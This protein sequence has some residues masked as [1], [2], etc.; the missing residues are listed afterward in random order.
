MSP[1]AREKSDV[2]PW[3][4]REWRA[5]QASSAVVAEMTIRRSLVSKNRSVISFD[6]PSTPD[7]P[8]IGMSIW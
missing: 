8:T 6:Q 5:R 3:R 4:L 2:S 1:K 7:M